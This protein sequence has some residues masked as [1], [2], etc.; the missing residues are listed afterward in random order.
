MSSELVKVGYVQKAPY[1]VFRA[2][3]G[4]EEVELYALPPLPKA[5]EDLVRERL[6]GFVAATA[7]HPQLGAVRGV[8]RLEGRLCLEQESVGGGCLAAYVSQFGLQLADALKMVRFMAR[9]LAGLHEAGLTHGNLNPWS[10]R[11][12]ADG[13]L[14][15]MDLGGP[16]P[17]GPW[18]RRF[19][20]PERD[21]T[22]ASDVYSLAMMVYGLLTPPRLLHDTLGGS[23]GDDAAWAAFHRDPDRRMPPLRPHIPL[24]RPVSELLQAM[25]D[26]RADAR[27][28]AAQVVDALTVAPRD[29]PSLETS[30]KIN[31]ASL[32]RGDALDPTRLIGLDLS[33]LDDP[34]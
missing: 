22:A 3:R 32:P 11:I 7:D 30:A 31:V 26:K 8:A 21:W 28:G 9:G 29:T 19:L 34:E 24:A 10:A 15:L 18:M 2:R 17:P 33:G 6:P 1:I 5:D 16:P 12:G 20:A 25:A 27:P 13:R 4:P 23:P 14:R